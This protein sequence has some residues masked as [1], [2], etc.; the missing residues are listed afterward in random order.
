MLAARTL[1]RS[2]IATVVLLLASLLGLPASGQPADSGAVAAGAGPAA[3][4]T[5]VTGDKVRLTPTP[6]GEPRVEFMPRGGD[7][8]RSFS[9][10]REAGRVEV[11]PHDVAR[12]VPE[13]LDPALF[14]V[15]GL[16]DMG[17]DDAHRN[18]LPLILRDAPGLRTKAATGLKASHAL[19]SLG[20]TATTLDKAGAAQFGQTLTELAGSVTA[21]PAP[22]AT[23]RALRNAGK[24][25][26]DGQVKTAELDAYL[27][28][29]GAPS[30]WDL[31]LDGSGVKVAV[32]DTGVDEGHPALAGQVDA[33]ANF[34]DEPTTDDGNG[35]GT[36][37]ASLVAGNGAGSDG[38]RRGVAAGADLLV[39]KVLNSE[40]F[41]Q[42]SWLIA[43]MEW[44]AAQGADV[45]NL[46]LGA[47]AGEA[48]DPV[49]LALDKLTAQYGTLFVVAAGNA[50]GL[51][52]NPATIGSPGIAASALTVAAVGSD[53]RQAGFS[54]EGPTRGTYRLKPDVAAPGVEILGARAGARTDDL[55]VPMMGTSQAAP[56]VAGAAALLLQQHP[57]LTWQQ[58]KARIVTTAA[59]NDTYTPWTVGGGRLDLAAA[60]SQPLTSDL[61]NLDFGYVKHPDESPRGKTVTITNT[62]AEPVTLQVTDQEFVEDFDFG[63][64]AAA[65]DT[66][67]VVSPA[68][69][70]VPAG[71]TATTT[72]TLDPAA[73]DDGIGGGSVLFASGGEAVLRLPVGFVDEPPRYDVHLKVL[74]RHGAPAA[75]R[76]NLKSGDDFYFAG[77]SLDENG[78]GTVRVP[79]GT[80]SAFATVVTPAAAGDPETYTIAGDSAV[81]VHADTTVVLDARAAKPL[82]APTITGQA[83][84]VADTVG[85][86]WSHMVP[87][88]GGFTDELYVEPEQIARGQV[89]IT[90]T[91]P[92][93]HG[94]FESALRWDLVPT[95]KIS[96][97]APA[98]YELFNTAPRFTDPLS[99]TIDPR[100]LARVEH[101]YRGA[102]Q[103]GPRVAGLGFTGQVSGISLIKFREID[104]PSTTSMLMTASP[105]VLWS[106]TLTLPDQWTPGLRAPYRSYAEG[107]RVSEVWGDGLHPGMYE[108][109]HSQYSLYIEVGVSDG[110]HVGFSPPAE[111][112]ES[113]RL[114]LHLGDD[115]IGTTEGQTGWFDIADRGG[116]FRLEQQSTFTKDALPIAR[117]ATTT[118]EFDS[119]PP[120]DPFQPDTYP[121]LLDLD[122]SL[123]VDALG[124]LEA[125]RAA[126]L[127][128]TVS[129]KSHFDYQ[130]ADVRAGSIWAS[131][132]EKTWVQLRTRLDGDA[133]HAVIPP[134]LLRPG[135]RLSLRAR[136]EAKDGA[137]VD[138]TVIGMYPVR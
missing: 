109:F 22:D 118:W 94:V 52:R 70:T 57:D 6:G 19:P 72:I 84:A 75:T 1:Q 100:K 56:I 11:I 88:W 3:T 42:S 2:A 55:Y 78:E 138:Q 39:G 36:H 76:V 113:S 122:Y 49:A 62:G 4:V 71:G 114:T 13:V 117:T 91:E 47:R 81:D 96:P 89:F 12:L 15:T 85:I 79:P 134:E 121:T 51:G 50:G 33:A 43:G 130:P 133:V 20:A 108:A 115:L 64:G 127:D 123:E 124:R 126:N 46:S 86:W 61:A 40:G 23:A 18:G 65:P 131:A 45:V 48:D 99:P 7:Q 92:V 105:A 30:A 54:S 125:N 136:A 37:V 16:V 107:E 25:W 29:V 26:L 128:L 21:A 137:S 129:R 73:V 119:H 104:V 8:R 60:T 98:V 93:T 77:V 31:G 28:Q 74:D 32:L 116:H 69:L 83:T 67:V 44:A 90:P 38:A 106:H 95:G 17:Y 24:I 135:G 97:N 101:T 27:S 58:L 87:G 120:S 53:D 5:L 102:G 59:T 41:G 132:D 112:L 35:H 66:A 68:N 82:R 10:R 34:T 9:V 111:S 14:D 80:F 103:P 110:E 63:G